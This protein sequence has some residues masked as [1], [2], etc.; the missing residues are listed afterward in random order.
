MAPVVR[1]VGDSKLESEETLLSGSG[2]PREEACGK[3]FSPGP[4]E[5]R[6][7]W[8]AASWAPASRWAWREEPRERALHLCVLRRAAAPAVARACGVRPDSSPAWERERGGRMRLGPG[9]QNV[10]LPP[11]A[12]PAFA[13]L[14]RREL[15]C[16]PAR[17]LI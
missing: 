1:D 10:R 17:P 4:A 3:R 6:G 5:G 16:R 8:G 13:P 9:A 12:S 2:P 7:S 11:P 15:A 14:T